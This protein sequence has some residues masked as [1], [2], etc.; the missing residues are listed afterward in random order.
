MPP[1]SGVARKEMSISSAIVM[2][3]LSRALPESAYVTEIRLE[4][5]NLRIMGL[6]DDAPGLLA[7]LERSEH[8]ADVHFFAPT[9]RGPDG[10]LFRFSIEARV[11]PRI[12]L[13]RIEVCRDSTVS[14]QFPSRFLFCCFWCARPWWGCCFRR[15]RR[16][17]G[18]FR[19]SRDTLAPR[20][21]AAS[22]RKSADRGGP[23]TAFLDA[24]TPGL[25][26]AQLQSYLAQL[27]GDQRAS[28][29]RPAEKLP[30][31]MTHLI[32]SGAG[33]A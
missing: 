2:E 30:S 25:A 12:R 28:L 17:A 32:R 18:K 20:S 6:A 5:E 10:K 31:A 24:S 29:F 8:M 13:G 23:P 15:A 11:E 3:A 14:R 9:A 4:K 19:T 7:P 1:Q 16:G 27:A 22:K 21:Q 26:S 33:H